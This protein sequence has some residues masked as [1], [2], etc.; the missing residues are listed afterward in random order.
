VFP[1]FP[2]EQASAARLRAEPSKWNE[3]AFTRAVDQVMKALDDWG[4]KF[5]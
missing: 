4:E 1:L 2:R 3:A 5:R